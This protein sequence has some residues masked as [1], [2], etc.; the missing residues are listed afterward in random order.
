MSAGRFVRY[1]GFESKPLEREYTFRVQSADG[2]PREFTLTIA[3][4]AFNSRRVR[5][6]DAPDIC[7]LKLRR[8]LESA[9]PPVE[10]HFRITDAE[11]EEYRSAHTQKVRRSLYSRRSAQKN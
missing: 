2:E 5:Y 1:L 9:A 10:S 6:Q 8:E 11:I 7:S 4:E 3:K